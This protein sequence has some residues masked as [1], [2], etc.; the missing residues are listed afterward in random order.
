MKVL[1]KVFS[2]CLAS[3]LFIAAMGV[4]LSGIK[5][6]GAKESPAGVVFPL[7]LAFLAC[8]GL[9]WVNT[10]SFGYS[11]IGALGGI[12]IG[13]PLSYLLFVPFGYWLADWLFPLSNLRL[14]GSLGGAWFSLG[15]IVMIEVLTDRLHHN[16]RWL[17][18]L[19]GVIVVMILAYGI[20]VITA[21]FGL[22]NNLS[23]IKLEIYTPLIWGCIVGLI[24]IRSFN[25]EN[26]RTNE[27]KK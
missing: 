8:Y 22:S 14:S 4:A 12:L 23:V 10:K 5:I 7:L 15:V 21:K 25:Q 26:R 13:L 1:L 17:M 18:M 27:H 2:A 19:L 16:N 20:E 6:L 9:A 11:F 3:W 24:N